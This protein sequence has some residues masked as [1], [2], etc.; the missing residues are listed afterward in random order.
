M[1]CEAYGTSTYSIPELSSALNTLGYCHRIRSRLHGK[2]EC[3]SGD[4]TRRSIFLVDDPALVVENALNFIVASLAEL[5]L[6]N[7]A[8]LK[9]LPLNQALREALATKRQSPYTY[10]VMSAMDYVNLIAR[11]SKL[12]GIQTEILRIQ[13]YS[14]RKEANAAVLAYLRGGSARA[15][16]E[17]LRKSSK[18]EKLL[19]FTLDNVELR[20]AYAR[21]AKEG[22]EAVATSTGIPSFELMYLRKAK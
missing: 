4:K 8:R 20:E 16:K 7:S 5:S 11:P 22:V 10:K 14:L 9:A 15:L 6:C 18:L 1:I 3:I 19:A 17:V 13:P 21:A 2:I 12:N